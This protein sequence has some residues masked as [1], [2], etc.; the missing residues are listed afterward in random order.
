LRTPFPQAETIKK[1][2]G[3]ALASMVE[4]DEPLTVEDA[5][6]RGPKQVSKRLLASIIEPRAEELLNLAEAE[7]RKSGLADALSAGIILTGGGAL[8]PGIDVLAEQVFG[9]PVRIGRPDRVNGPR[10]VTANP[11]YATA[12][13]L[14]RCALEGKCRHLH[15]LPSPG[16]GRRVWEDLKGWFS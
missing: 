15:R 1:T 11:G 13:G 16:L 2:H 4:K 8:L 3:T 6:G 12:V 7:L 5:S 14:V 9:K 10:D